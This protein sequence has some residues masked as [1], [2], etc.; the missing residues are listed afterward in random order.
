VEVA[1]GG[2]ERVNAE[3]EGLR[4]G[5]GI[6][7]AVVVAF[8]VVV[9][10][11]VAVAGVDTTLLS[12]GIVESGAGVSCGVLEGS[13]VETGGAGSGVAVCVGGWGVWEADTCEA[14]L[15]RLGGAAGAGAARRT[16]ALGANFLPDLSIVDDN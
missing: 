13:A 7:I 4:F 8:C 5:R 3:K 15:G 2:C 14:I 16:G 6:G 1:L 9:E 12:W 11:V 10:V